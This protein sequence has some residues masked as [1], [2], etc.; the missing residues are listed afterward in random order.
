[1]VQGRNLR[2]DDIAKYWPNSGHPCKSL[3]A[4][5]DMEYYRVGSLAGYQGICWG[6]KICSCRQWQDAVYFVLAK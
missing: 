2:K 3:G 4:S 1:M 6:K 5:L